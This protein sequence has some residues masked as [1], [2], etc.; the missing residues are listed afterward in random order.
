MDLAGASRNRAGL[1]LFATPANEPR[2]R[3]ASDALQLAGAAVGLALLGWT[4][5]PPAGF[6][7]AVD[8]FL[9]SW[10]TFLHGLWQVALDLLALAAV[11]VA[12]ASMVRRRWSLVRDLALAA[13]VAVAIALLAGRIVEGSWPAV[14]DA[15]RAS[16]PP[17]W[18]PSQRIAVPGAVLAAANPYLSLPMRRTLRR[19]LGVAVVGVT[20]LGAATIAGAV[21][22]AFV[23]VM[24]A[25]SVHLLLGSCGGRPGLGDVAAALRELGVQPQSLEAA[26]RQPTGLFL[27][28]AHDDHGPLEVKVYGRDA[29]DTR[30][31]ASL[32]RLIWYRSGEAS[33]A[34]S[35]RQHVEHE[36]LLTLL[37]AQAGVVTQAVVT[38]SATASD[39]ALLVLRPVG[40]PLDDQPAPADPEE[41][42]R[43]AG[44]LWEAVG[45]LH[46]A[47]IG[48]G[49]IDSSHLVVVDGE[50]GVIGFRGAGVAVVPERLQS[51]R[52]QTLV[53]AALAFG[54]DPALATAVTELGRDGLGEV[55]P[56]LQ[57]RALTANQRAQLRDADL[58]LD[59]LLQ[60]AADAAGVASPELRELRRVSGRSLFQSAMLV[61]AFAALARGVAQVDFEVLRATLSDTIWWLAFATALFGQLPRL[62]QSVSTLGACPL[63]MP[64]GPVY[65]LQLAVSY[66]NLAVP[67]SA[68]RIAVNVRFFQR[69]GL[70][71]GSA[72][73]IGALDGFSGFIIQAGLLSSLL[74]F[75]PASLEVDLDVDLM[76]KATDLAAIVLGFVVV[77][78]VVVLVLPKLR[79]TII[80]WVTGFVRDAL[81]ALRGLHSPRRL[82]MLVG[83]NLAT[84]VLFAMTL[85]GFTRALGYSV[86]LS[87]L[88]LVNMSVALL[89]GLAPVPGGIGV[90]EGAL[91]VGLIGAGLPEEPALG[92]VI[93]YRLATFYLPP[94][95]GFFAFRWLERNRHL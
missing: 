63:P 16:E 41:A 57:P 10:P 14:W 33:L 47:G 3:R 93:L 48:H 80:T 27:V 46:R 11:A 44:S 35:R 68:A 74:L 49:Q 38:A 52:A 37:A 70:S 6:L 7:R 78:A 67:S 85:G 2:A 87:T 77:A 50:I 56:Y 34:L 25:A 17:A 82:A 32:W 36:A 18:F 54:I 90:S 28:Q 66:I 51:D 9:L 23:A 75:T 15:L 53:A 21:A 45:R 4:A 22:G 62:T 64:L 86:G 84:E 24:A 58:D 8:T 12:A 39:D 72:A 26:A 89:S 81:E 20:C 1:K 69:H 40:Q 71:A 65:A 92:A 29:H 79:R 55:L 76:S 91:T 5:L 43:L 60:R 83:G 30:L 19:L 73:T 31:I 88:L 59:D 95:W 61:V 94:I 13:L 42:A